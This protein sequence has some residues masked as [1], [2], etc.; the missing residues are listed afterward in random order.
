[1]TRAER[2]EQLLGHARSV[3]A[4]HGYEGASVE[5]IAARAEVSKP[6]V[7]EHFGGKEGL[8]GAVVDREMSLLSDGIRTAL[9]P[10]VDDPDPAEQVVSDVESRVLLERAT[11]ALLD[12]IE[13]R[14]DGFRLLSRGSGVGQ[15]SGSFATILSE[16]GSQVTDLLADAFAERR[17][18]P[19]I[20][21]IYAQMLV[22]MVA[23]T[24]QWWL[25]ERRPSKEQVAAHLVNLAWNGLSGI[26]RRP[27]LT[28]PER[29][30]RRR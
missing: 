5:E 1:M 12:Y 30:L 7:Y 10:S 9:D 27:R 16:V 4:D 6:I 25:D 17:L 29:V 18:D 19:Q 21:P 26:E 2:R 13:R 24:G 14:P 8:Y 22:G 11:L 28:E 15:A 23:M 20:A 3:F